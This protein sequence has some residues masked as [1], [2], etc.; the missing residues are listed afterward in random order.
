VLD[1]NY[2]EDKDLYMCEFKV[3]LVQKGKDTIG[4]MIASVSKD[5]TIVK[6]K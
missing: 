2:W 6:R 1:V 3:R 5:M 4:V